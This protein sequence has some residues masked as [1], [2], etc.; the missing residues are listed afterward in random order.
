MFPI[1]VEHSGGNDVCESPEQL[2]TVLQ[3]TV[4]GENE[5]LLSQDSEVL[6]PFVSLLVTGE[7]GYIWYLPYDESAGIQA[8]GEDI[9]LDPEGST[10]FHINN[11]EEMYI[12]NSYVN[13][14]E[15]AIQIVLDLVLQDSWPNCYEDM[16]ESAEWEEL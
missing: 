5:F 13:Q 2:T 4:D 14:K 15:T 1:F 16:P 9:G 6:I 8:Y 12:P 7:Y 10:I 11:T 3:K